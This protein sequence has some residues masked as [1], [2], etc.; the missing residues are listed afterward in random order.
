MKELTHVEVLKCIDFWNY[1]TLN[2]DFG[3][4]TLTDK[5]EGALEVYMCIGRNHKPNKNKMKNIRV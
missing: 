1:P 2:L 3:P 5:V 4:H